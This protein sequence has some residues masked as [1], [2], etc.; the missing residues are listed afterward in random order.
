MTDEQTHDEE[1]DAIL[2]ELVEAGYVEE[3]TGDD[4]QPAMRLTASGEQVAR[5]LA[6]SGSGR[7]ASTSSRVS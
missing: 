1:F 3:Y 2:G 6:K 7:G 5:Q 4:G